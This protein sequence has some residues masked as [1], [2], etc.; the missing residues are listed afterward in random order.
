MRKAVLDGAVWPQFHRRVDNRV[1]ETAVRASRPAGRVLVGL[2]GEGRRAARTGYAVV[3]GG[4][5]AYQYT[6]ALAGLL[7][8]SGQPRAITRYLARPDAVFIKPTDAP[9]P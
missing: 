3:R 5:V 1:N 8:A 2:R 7:H 9:A 4:Q 6:Q